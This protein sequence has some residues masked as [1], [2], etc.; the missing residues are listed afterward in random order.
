MEVTKRHARRRA[1]TRDTAPPA[2]PPDLDAGDAS[3]D[4]A[5]VV[6]DVSVLCPRHAA[7]QD[8]ALLT[9]DARI[10]VDASR[11]SMAVRRRER[12]VE[13]EDVVGVV[14][15]FDAGEAVVV[16]AVVCAGAVGEVGIGE[17]GKDAARSP[18]A[19]CRMRA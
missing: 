4:V 8:N 19:G 14:A 10:G 7:R 16:N 12:L 9:G 18:Q 15:R 13:A 6:S 5:R 2:N 3:R 11:I 1:I 17:V